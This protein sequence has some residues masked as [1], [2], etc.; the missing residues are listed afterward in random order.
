[1]RPRHPF[2]GLALCA[3]CGV[4]VAD[5]WAL[6][7]VPLTAG[8]ALAA[9]AAFWMPRSALAWMAALL[10]FALV[11]TLAFRMHPARAIEAALAAG[12]RIVEAQGIVTNDPE[13]LPYFSKHHSG[14]FEMRIASLEGPEIGRFTEGA[15]RITWAGPLPKFGDRVALHGTL[16]ALEPVSNP[17]QFDF[18]DFS[19]RR[20]I[21]AQMEARFAE[22]CRVLGSGQAHPLFALAHSSRQWMET[23]LAL[24][25]DDAPEIRSVISSMVLGLRDETP[26]ELEDLFSRTGTLH[27]FAISGLHVGLLC[28][29]A[30]QVLRPL[31]LG[32]RI[33]PFAVLVVL[34]FYAVLT[35]L[36]ASVLRATIMAAVVLLAAVIE[37]RPHSFNSLAASAVIIIAADTNQVF[38]AGFQLSF[39]LVAAILWLGMGITRRI[40]PFIRPDPYLPEPLWTLRQRGMAVF[41]KAFATSAGI[42]IAAWLGSLV[43]TAGFFH[44]FSPVALVAN[45]VAVPFSF[46]VLALGLATILAAPFSP[47][48]AGLFS[49]ANWLCTKGLIW[50]VEQFALLPGGYWYVELPRT[51]RPPAAEV[52]VL[53]MGAGA[54]I[55]L[56]SGGEDWLI[57]AG[58]AQ[59]YTGLLSY[60]R[61]RGVNRL[62]GFV[63]THG[64]AQHIGGAENL[65]ADLE[66][67]AVFDSTLKNRSPTRRKVHAALARRGRGKAFLARG[68]RLAAGAFHIEVLFPP[69]GWN[70]PAADDKPLILLGE[71]QGRSILFLSDAG[72]HAER[73]LVENHPAL[74]ADVFI[75]GMPAKDTAGTSDLLALARPAVVVLAAPEFGATPAA[76]DAWA[77]MA[78]AHG[79]VVFR[80]ETSGAVS[81]AIR[82]GGLDVRAWRSP[83]TFRS[84]A[85]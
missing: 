17:G 12:P 41:G 23:Q 2:L 25:L 38:S 77:A 74:E 82:D 7:A 61:S 53:D 9:L 83:Q 65:L 18:A 85:R 72:L 37:H 48:L 64:D 62:D 26:E 32:R 44:L 81:I 80:Q 47:A 66:P 56:R 33:L 22:D 70:R 8:F 20:G 78:Q 29:I 42:S 76:H 30:I 58:P 59:R 5:A 15:L 73:W 1:M 10:G 19:R 51:L 13:P 35:G 14:C 52:Q 40:E 31:G 54:A 84:R 16:R 49:N 60:L 43:L 79:A 69:P 67:R 4:A 75:K 63:L 3:L 24:E 34:V 55:H 68:A 21:F 6:P 36:T 71:C 50:S 46:G 11:H 57:D 27:L 28:V 39:V 45:L